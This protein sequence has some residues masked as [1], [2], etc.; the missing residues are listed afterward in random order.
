ML[1][2]TLPPVWDYLASVTFPRALLV[3]ALMGFAI[4]CGIAAGPVATATEAVPYG[5]G[6][7]VAVALAACGAVAYRNGQPQRR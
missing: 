1:W 2:V 5:A 7:A 3:S 4:Y 6:A